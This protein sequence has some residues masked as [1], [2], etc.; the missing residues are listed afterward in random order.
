[1]RT[2]EDLL[3]REQIASACKLGKLGHPHE[4]LADGREIC[5]GA[6]IPDGILAGRDWS[7]GLVRV[8]NLT[9]TQYEAAL[10]WQRGQGK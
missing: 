6:Y 1:M 3:A 10:E 8:Y 9:P 5:Q 7:T 2:F 4:I